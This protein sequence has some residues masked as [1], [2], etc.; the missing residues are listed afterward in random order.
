MNVEAFKAGLSQF[1]I[2]ILL[3]LGL[4]VFN[5]GFILGDA[6]AQWFQSL[7]AWMQF[8]GA[9]ILRGEIWRLFTGHLVHWSAAHFY[10]DAAVFI[11][12]GI[13]FEPKIGRQY[14]RTLALAAGAIGLG[15][16]IFQRDLGAYRGISGLINTQF[17]LGTGLFVF[18]ASLK[19][20]VKGFYVAIFSIHIFKI[21]Y[22]IFFQVSFF[23]TDALGDMGRFTPL[24]H[25]AGALVGLGYLVKLAWPS[26][27]K[28]A[29]SGSLGTWG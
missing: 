3:T 23:S 6:Q 17:V 13:V 7:C 16:L 19:R 4:C 21:G 11:A 14:A 22:E 27:L 15:L 2:T 28:P 29:P 25:L 1:K 24:A 9:S 18:D 26:Q 20:R 8:D 5:A 10:L 12:Q